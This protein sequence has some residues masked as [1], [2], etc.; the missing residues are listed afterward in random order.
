MPELKFDFRP[1][2]WLPGPHLP[3]VWAKLGR[4]R[5]SLHDRVERVPTPDGDHVTLARMGRITPGTPH[6][7][8]LH[9]LEGKI[10]A[11]YAQGLLAEAK[12][13]GWSGDLM[14]FRSCDGEVNTARRFYH[15]GET[16]DIDFI[17]RKLTTEHP[18]IQ[19]VIAGVS[20]GGNVTLKWLGEMGS[21]Y[22]RQLRRVAAI[23]TPFDLEAGATYMERGISPFYLRHFLSTLI[24]KTLKKMEQ[25]PDLCNRELLLEARTFR[26]FDDVLTGPLHG[27]RDAHDYYVRSS[28][29]GFIDRI[30]VDTLLMNSWDDPF[31]PPE[32]LRRV[33]AIAAGNP[34]LQLLF[35]EY[36]GHVGWVQGPP[37]SPTYPMEDRVMRFLEEGS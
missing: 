15:S 19:L 12:K 14:L 1:A 32:I 23:S 18:W 6:L 16:T 37:W 29:I 25:Y 30:Q 34:K 22:P 21:N 31:L 11:K 13:R 20:L 28:S 5:P 33:R 4:I 3:T 36:G 9:G 7:V 24:G 35:T 26:D 17:V 8:V 2:W 27:F 10:S